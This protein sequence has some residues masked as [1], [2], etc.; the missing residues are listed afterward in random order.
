MA[1]ELSTLRYGRLE[2]TFCRK[3]KWSYIGQIEELS[4]KNSKQERKGN[5]IMHGPEDKTPGA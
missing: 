5:F 3:F 4:G 1:E 2:K